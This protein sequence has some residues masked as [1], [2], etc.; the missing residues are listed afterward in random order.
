[1]YGKI[2]EHRLISSPY[3]LI[4]IIC[5]GNNQNILIKIKSLTNTIL[6]YVN[7]TC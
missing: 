7:N 1:M 5:Y 2:D 3:I 6:I 4:I